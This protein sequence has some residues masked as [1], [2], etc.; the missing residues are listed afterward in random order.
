MYDA[1]KKIKRLK[2]PQKLLIKGKDGL[3]ANPTEQRKIAAEYFKKT[4]YTNKQPIRA[5]PPT[6]MAIPFTEDEIRKVIAK[7]KPNKSPG[8][9]EIPV[10]IIKYTAKTIHEQIAEI[11]NTMAETGDTT[12][13]IT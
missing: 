9:D 6:K 13:E 5:I 7:M 10:E 2:P 3:T 4:F 1:L 8:C 12:R 11:Y